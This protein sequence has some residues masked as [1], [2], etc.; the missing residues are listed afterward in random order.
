MTIGRRRRRLP[1]GRVY[2]LKWG[3]EPFI[4][5]DEADVQTL[6]EFKGEC[7]SGSVGKIPLFELAEPDPPDAA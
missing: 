3:E 6:L 1:S 7:C 4:D 2:H 5:V